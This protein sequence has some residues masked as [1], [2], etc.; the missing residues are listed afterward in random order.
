MKGDIDGMDLILITCLI[1]GFVTGE[2]GPTGFFVGI[3]L[4]LVIGELWQSKK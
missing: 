4:T 2:W 3:T 1:G